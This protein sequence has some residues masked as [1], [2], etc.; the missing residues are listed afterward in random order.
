MLNAE[1][2][3]LFVALLDGVGKR[4][5]RHARASVANGMKANLKIVLRPL[6]G[7]SVELVL[8]IARYA[9]VFW[10]VGIGRE[11]G[12]SARSQR[13]IHESF[14]HCGMQHGIVLRVMLA[15][16]DQLLHWRVKGQPLSDAQCEL[17]FFFHLLIGEEVF[18]IRVV[19][20]R[21]DAML[22]G[23]CERQFSGSTA[24]CRTGWRNPLPDQSHGGFTQNTGGL[25]FS[26]AVN[27]AAVWVRTLRC[28]A[29][30]F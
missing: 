18:P 13:S 19:L 11:H 28:Y 21:C 24:L 3:I 17:A 8:L 10:I 12:C 6:C 20:R 16:F 29:C 9:G 27:L 7:H 5:Q 30:S 2:E 14:Q 15:H 22:R 4:V 25:T 26:I 23:V 1:A